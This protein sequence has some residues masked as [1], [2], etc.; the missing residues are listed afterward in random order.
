M[1]IMLEVA[2]MNVKKYT[3][4]A[5]RV[6]KQERQ[7]SLTS[8]TWLNKMLLVI[9]H[10]LNCYEMC[11]SRGSSVGT[12]TRLRAGRQGF[13]SWQGQGFLSRPSLGPTQPPI[14]WI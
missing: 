13:N 1:T 8:Q 6:T 5:T 12:K 11:R 9:P 2:N 10:A 3:E 4:V 7:R 14:Q